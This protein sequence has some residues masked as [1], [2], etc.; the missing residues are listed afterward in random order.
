MGLSAT[1]AYAEFLTG[2][3][4]PDVRSKATDSK[5]EPPTVRD[6]QVMNDQCKIE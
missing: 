2:W 3:G 4:Q 5:R 1:G 6:N